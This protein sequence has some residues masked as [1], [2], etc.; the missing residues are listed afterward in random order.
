VTRLVEE[1]KAREAAEIRF[2]AG[3]I[4]TGPKTVVEDVAFAKKVALKIDKYCREN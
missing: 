4:V 1:K 3:D 2:V